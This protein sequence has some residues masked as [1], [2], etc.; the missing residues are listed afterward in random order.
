MPS[1]KPTFARA[2]EVLKKTFGYDSFHPTQAAAIKSVLAGDDTFVLMPTGGGKSVC[3]QVPALLFPGTTIVVS[4]LIAL[5]KDQVDGLRA[6][7]VA[8]EYLNS[9]LEYEDQ[10]EITTR[11]LA[12]EIKLLYISAERLVSPDFTSILK[13]IK[14]SLFA[15]DEA[16]CISSWG[17]DFRPD[18][19]KLSHLK[20]NFPKVPIIALTATADHI[21]RRDILAQLK[22]DEPQEF[23]DSFDRPNISLTVEA[24][25]NKKEKIAAFLSTKPGQSGIIYCLTR[26]QTEELADALQGMGFTAAS[27]HAGMSSAERSSVQRSFVRDKT[28]IMCATIAFGM[29]IDK[30]NVRWVIHYS[31]P[32]NI[33]G[34]YQEIGRSGRDSAPAQALLF[35]SYADVEMIKRFF[36]DKTQGA[37]QQAK[38]DRIKEFAEGVICRRKIL[39]NYFG[40]EYSDDCGNCDVCEQPFTTLNGT[41]ISQHIL[42]TVLQMSSQGSCQTKELVSALTQLSDKVSFASWHFYVAQLKNQGLIT[43][44]FSEQTLQLS[45]KG[46]ATLADKLPVRLVLLDTFI[47]RQQSGESSD[48]KPLSKRGKKSKKRKSAEYDNPLFEKLRHK[49]L[50]LAQENSI[51][52]YMI[53][54]DTTLLELA[55]KQPKTKA[56]MLEISGIGEVKWQR[57]GKDFLQ[58]LTAEA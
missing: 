22:L 13:K 23:V 14:I 19:T 2:Q 44:D 1:L 28:Q 57:Y 6:N 46:T 29:G 40:E 49:R 52:A 37:L 33:E 41:E 4:P 20:S 31:L 48:L 42:N 38:L 10:H 5:M 24:G 39:L 7:G 30:S 12:G 43:I 36:L 58:V 32:K 8:A 17:H 25:V 54:S 47:E 3:F 15:I 53:F 34:Y 18:Y 51:A 26:K 21:T 9:S 35:Y 45:E 56:Q 50:V 16:H 27:Y 55:Q 11:L